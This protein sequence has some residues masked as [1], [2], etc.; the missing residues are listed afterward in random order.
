MD[1]RETP[2][3]SPIRPTAT[4]QPPV[5]RTEE[6][7][8]AGISKAQRDLF[9]SDLSDIRYDKLTQAQQDVKSHYEESLNI[10]LVDL[11]RLRQ[12]KGGS[13]P[14]ISVM[15][16]VPDD[17]LIDPTDKPHKYASTFVTFVL[18]DKTFPPPRVTLV[19]LARNRGDSLSIL[20][21]IGEPDNPYP[22]DNR[23]VLLRSKREIL[24][25]KGVFISTDSSDAE[26]QEAVAIMAQV[27]RRMLRIRKLYPNKDL[28]I[29]AGLNPENKNEIRIRFGKGGGSHVFIPRVPELLEV[30][31]EFR[32]GATKQ[33]PVA[34]PVAQEKAA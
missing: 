8:L 10:E 11:L 23:D 34:T 1:V 3:P 21:L 24:K 28:P 19:T 18:P 15:L 31:E 6:S 33:T 20:K 25:T 27:F 7:I 17:G 2:P 26:R 12:S 30:L 29:R 4:E 14:G 32:P 5:L 16:D 9:E 13:L 22:E